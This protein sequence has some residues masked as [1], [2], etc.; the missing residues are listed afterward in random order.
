MHT[1]KT[2]PI[3]FLG[4]RALMS[5]IFLVAG[6]S[7]ISAYAATQGYMESVGIPG[8]LLP[9][10]IVLEIGGGLALLLGVSARLAA[11]ALAGFSIVSAVLFHADFGDQTQSIMFLKNLALAGSLGVA[12]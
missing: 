3:L 1:E 12:V 4:G 8:A 11:V 5:V 2:Q 6:I 9:L 7:K 10:V